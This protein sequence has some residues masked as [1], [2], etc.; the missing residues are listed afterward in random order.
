MRRTFTS[1]VAVLSFLLMFHVG[2]VAGA[3]QAGAPQ[4]INLAERLAAGQLRPVNRAATPLADRAG[5][6][7]VSQQEG[8]GVVWLEGSEL[9]RG[10]IEVNV[11]GRDV[12]GL[13]FVGVAF[14]RRDDDTYDAVYV[15]PFNFRIDDPVRRQNAVQYMA[16]PDYDWPRLRKEFPGEFENPVDPSVS[17]TDW[18]PLRVVVSER[19]IQ[20]YV[21]TVTTPTLEVRRLGSHGRGAVGLWVGNNSDGAFADLQI[22]PA[23]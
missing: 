14:H 8:P 7:H 23:N 18:I 22:T 4:R 1:P 2:G 13:S 11:R 15:R 17:P 12:Q 9:S 5:A 19:T 6:V 20:V 3:R 10:T 21:G 16:V